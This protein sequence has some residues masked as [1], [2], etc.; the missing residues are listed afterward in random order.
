MRRLLPFRV[1]IWF[2]LS[3]ALLILMGFLEY[4]IMQRVMAANQWVR[5]TNAVLAAIE[6]TRSSLVRATSL[7]RQYDVTGRDDAL[8]GY[9]P[10]SQKLE[11][12]VD[13]VENLTA[14]NPTQRENVQ[15][16]R[17]LIKA[18]LAVSGE[19]ISWRKLH[20]PP[21][22]APSA[23]ASAVLT[24]SISDL[25]DQ[26]QATEHYLFDSRDRQVQAGVR[27]ETVVL[28]LGVLIA[29]AIFSFAGAERHRAAQDREQAHAAVLHSEAKFRGLLEAAPDAMVVMNGKGKIILVNAQVEE[30]FGY[31]RAKLLEHEI[32]LLI[33]EQGNERR[34]GGGLF[35][36]SGVREIRSVVELSG[37]HK[38]GREFPVE[39]TLSPLQTEEGLLIVG[40]IRDITQRKRAEAS[41]EQ[42][43]SIVDHSND[44]IIGK[45]LDGTIVNWN[46]GAER[47]YG[48]S[49][50]EVIGKPVSILLPPDRVQELPPIMARL[51]RG[52]TISREETVR[53]RKDG[54]LVDVSLTISPIKDAKGQVVGAS[55]I[56]HDITERKR[57]EEAIR[58]ANEE[59]ETRVIERTAE[60]AQANR[61]LELEL[62]ERRKAEGLL[63]LRT[64]ALEAAANTIVMTDRNGQIVWANAAL[65]ALTGYSAEEVLGQNPG[66][67]KSGKQDQNYYEELWS[68]ILAGEVWHGEIVNRRKNGTLY[69]EEMTI[70]PVRDEHGEISH[71]IAIKQD[72]TL[73][74]RAEEARRRS[75]ERFRA[76]VTATSDV[77]Y[78]M[79]PDWGEM[80]QLHG[81]DFIADTEVPSRGWI[82]KYIHPDDQPQVMARI[83]EAIQTQS[84]FELEHR[85]LRVDGTLGW[86]FSRA[87]PLR[88]AN[89][90]IVEWF[91]A[92]TD[93]TARKL[94]EQEIMQ[95]NANLERR[96]AERTAELA[97]AN[98]ELEAFTYSVA[99]DLR[100]PLRHINGFARILV[101]DHGGALNTDAREFLAQ[102]QNG[103]TQMGRLVDDLLHLARL[104]RQAMDWRQVDLA[105]LV[106]EV[107][108]ELQSETSGRPIEWRVSELP[109]ARCDRVLVKQ[110]LVNLLSNAVKYTRGRNPAVIEIGCDESEG[111]KAFFVRDNGVGFNMAYAQKLF[112][113]FQRLHSQEEFEGTGVGLAVVHRVCQRHG[114]RVWAEAEPDKG[115]T[116]HFTLGSD[117]E[118]G[119]PAKN[120]KEAFQN[121]NENR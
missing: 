46:K 29:V 70:T 64:E 48:Y 27:R 86:T 10:A 69:T 102:I 71:F 4:E 57:A 56:T 101:E 79:S 41:R 81:Q 92:A 97:A 89:G 87:V 12:D 74:R 11:R 103:A 16:L 9:Q 121:H 36:E 115:A 52:E 23:D 65:T 30:L 24:S 33:P 75:E 85:V 5:H 114:G 108:R 21:A 25:T 47:V 3:F 90:E 18:K 68:T 105:D 49:A 26:M 63:R 8:A 31:T 96:V 19:V 98:Q 60:L 104:G 76:L 35:T 7:M 44:A 38:D 77:V 111:K 37:W 72:V 61:K 78:R 2:G 112:G 107:V 42:L 43:A 95:L 99:H 13:K 45:A 17:T 20:G 91:G 55:T 83:R 54:S 40:A 66:I 106:A 1:E 62:A 109:S 73:R 14:D 51:E 93:V 22:S 118:A 53:R 113:L 32:K 119:V 50:S 34:Q 59:L 15:R 80:R 100:A 110:A 120:S 6:D 84:T 88:N 39:I 116:F 67:F 28:L 94:A 82:D 117:D 58:R